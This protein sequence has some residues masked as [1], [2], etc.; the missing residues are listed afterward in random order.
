M[1]IVSK[2]GAKLPCTDSVVRYRMNET[3]MWNVE[4]PP[5]HLWTTVTPNKPVTMGL[6][7]LPFEVES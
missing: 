4:P 2:F 5:L 6:S 7:N 1:G 3:M